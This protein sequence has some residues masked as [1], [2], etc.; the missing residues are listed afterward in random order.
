MRSNA[1]GNY[2]NYNRIN[3]RLILGFSLQYTLLTIVQSNKVYNK[4]IYKSTYT[5]V[6]NFTFEIR[7]NCWYC[8]GARYRFR[9]SSGS[10]RRFYAHDSSYLCS[11]EFK[12]NVLLSSKFI[13]Q[14]FEHFTNLVNKNIYCI[15][16]C[17][18]QNK[19]NPMIA[20]LPKT[21]RPSVLV[22]SIFSKNYPNYPV[23]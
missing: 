19:T 13:F 20:Y 22:F 5:I 4:I 23:P 1:F 12:S 16:I 3:G 2:N 10:S 15:Q 17:F 8:D 18:N 14:P 21:I 7:K 6:L 9:T 11:K